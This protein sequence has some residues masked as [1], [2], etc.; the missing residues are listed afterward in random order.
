[1]DWEKWKR[2]FGKAAVVFFILGVIFSLIYLI[3]PYA[4]CKF[5]LDPIGDV[6]SEV[7]RECANDLRYYNSTPTQIISIGIVFSG[8]LFLFFL[9]IIVFWETVDFVKNIEKKL[10]KEK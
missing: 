2:R 8:L 3:V 5:T 10:L 1:M 4:I 7:L 6:E 9:G